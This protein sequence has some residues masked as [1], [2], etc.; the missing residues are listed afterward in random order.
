MGKISEALGIVEVKGLIAAVT[1]TDAM[2]KAANIRI[3]D[4]I[5]IGSAHTDSLLM[6]APLSTLDTLILGRVAEKRNR[7]LKVLSANG[8]LRRETPQVLPGTLASEEDRVRK[9][10][11]ERVGPARPFGCPAPLATRLQEGKPW[12]EDL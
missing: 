10:L 9:A 4:K 3:L 1:A 12:F 5:A 6:I 2:A 11:P 7:S 8:A